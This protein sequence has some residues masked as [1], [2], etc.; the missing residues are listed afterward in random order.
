M[1]HSVRLC[2]VKCCPALKQEEVEE[3]CIIVDRRP[4]ERDNYLRTPTFSDVGH[5]I[6][7]SWRVIEKNVMVKTS[8][9]H[10]S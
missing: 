7:R 8:T 9:A 6:F 3:L 5:H 1:W 10:D 4:P 2:G